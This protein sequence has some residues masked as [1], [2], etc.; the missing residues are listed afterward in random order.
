MFASCGVFVD[1]GPTEMP[2]RSNNIQD[3]DSGTHGMQDRAGESTLPV[4]LGS[5][6]NLII[7][8][9]TSKRKDTPGQRA[10]RQQLGWKQ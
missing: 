8:V 4:Y 1:N 5:K 3:L 7:Q 9:E 10:L 2:E 6:Q